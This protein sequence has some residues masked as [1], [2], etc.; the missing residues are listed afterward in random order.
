MRSKW[1]KA[2]TS[3][4]NS[5]LVCTLIGVACKIALRRARIVCVFPVPG[6]P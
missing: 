1:L 2:N 6:G 3:Q 4:K 5:H